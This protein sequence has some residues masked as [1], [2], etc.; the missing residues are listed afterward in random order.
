MESEKFL[1]CSSV[2]TLKE[3]ANNP[4]DLTV[5][6]I[7]SEERIARFS[8]SCSIFTLSYATERVTDDVLEALLALSQ[9]RELVKQMECM[10]QGCIVNQIYGYPSESRPALHTATRAWIQSNHSLSEP[11][12]MIAAKAA[13]ECQRLQ[14]FLEKVRSSFSTIV[15]IGIGGSELGPKALYHALFGLWDTDKEVHFVSNIDPDEVSRVLKQ[16]SCKDTLVVVVS[17]SGTTQE[18]SVNEAFFKEHFA[19]QGCS[20]D[21]HFVAVTCEGSAMDDPSRYLEVFHLWES[22]GGRFS[23]TSMVGGVILGFAFGFDVFLQILSGAA[24]M[25]SLALDPNIK[26]NVSLMSAL[27]GIWNRNFLGYPTLAVI[28]YASGLQF[29]PAHLQQCSMESNGKSIDVLGRFVSFKTAPVLWGEV[30][31][32]S[33]HSFFQ[34]IHQGTD[35]I[36]LEFIGFLKNQLGKDFVVSGSTSTEKLFANMLAQSI[37]LAKGEH[38]EHPNRYFPGN[39]PSSLLVAKQLTPYVLGALLAFYEH[40]FAF[41][42][43]CWGINSFDQE[44]VSLGKTLTHQIL[45]DMQTIQENQNSFSEAKALLRLFNAL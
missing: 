2:Q 37:A 14:L 16:I 29:F 18:T 44:G 33:Q 27:L 10:Q 11:A 8:S 15:Q 19:E 22:I 35:I 39:R 26:K 25:D 17:K 1:N 7:L 34:C 24:Y 32:N 38:N 21:Q 31:T 12:Q 43:F 45:A 36:P 4:L 28:P 6:G 5:P 9:E 20:F 42:G 30:G 13:K 3:L 40:K 41:Q 23:S